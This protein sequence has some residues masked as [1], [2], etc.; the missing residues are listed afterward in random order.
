MSV[1][2]SSSNT[3]LFN[4]FSMYIDTCKSNLNI[5]E[6]ASYILDMAKD[7]CDMKQLSNYIIL[8]FSVCDKYDINDEKP[9]FY[10]LFKSLS[11]YFPDVALG[12]LK[13][14]PYYGSYKDY[15]SLYNVY[16][17]N[18]EFKKAIIK[19]YGEQLVSDMKIVEKS[20]D[21]N[22]YLTIS[23]AA[24]YASRGKTNIYFNF[25][26]DI[27]KELFKDSKTLHKDYRK[28]IVKLTRHIKTPEVFF[29]PKNIEKIDNIETYNELKR[30]IIINDDMKCNITPTQILNNLIINSNNNN[31]QSEL[32]NV[33]WTQLKDNINNKNSMKHIMPIIN[34]NEHM[35]SDTIFNMYSLAIFMSDVTEHSIH[36]TNVY[37]SSLYFNDKKSLIDRYKCVKNHFQKSNIFDIYQF[38]VR[39]LKNMIELN[40]M[41][42]KVPELLIFSDMSFENNYTLDKYTKLFIDLEIEYRK[43]GMILHNKSFPIPKI[44]FWDIRQKTNS[45]YIISSIPNVSVISNNNNT[46][47]LS[48]YFNNNNNIIK[49]DFNNDRYERLKYVL[50][51]Q[52]NNIFNAE[53]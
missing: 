45:N 17:G 33:L 25:F 10:T 14:I 44:V 37:E 3:E 31:L 28:F 29:Q 35:C 51:T 34:F 20:N 1:V 5:I 6:Y 24:K 39:I 9:V 43:Y 16:E 30:Q 15:L 50:K 53:C 32:Y 42:D 36:S 48:N 22:K 8:M 7:S 18:S 38:M 13:E 52:C 19:I 23:Q 26:I 47:V 21:L 41:P 2:N 12:L 4:N 11:Y 40:T 46:N 27:V 49:N